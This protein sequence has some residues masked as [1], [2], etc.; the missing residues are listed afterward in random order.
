MLED[1]TCSNSTP[2]PDWQ[3]L[4]SL[5]DESAVKHHHLCP[6]QILGIRIGLAG[7]RALN[8]I[9]ESYQSRFR[10]PQKRLLTIVETD[11]C[12]ADGVAVATDC[13]VGRRT[14]RV[15]D[16]GKVA[17]SLV[18][19]LSGRAIRIAPAPVARKLA[20]K[21]AP[22]ESSPWH[23]YLEAY[24][25]M[26][27]GELLVIQPVKLTRSL[28][29]ILSRPGLRVVCQRCGEEIMNE[30]QVLQ[31]GF[32]MCR[33]CAGEAYYRCLPSDKGD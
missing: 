29:E 3:L 33:G 27:D 14:L 28:A 4:S 17:A 16:F 7:L 1:P 32:T 5:M 21:R 24:Q 12:G 23:S 22:D 26:P 6:R 20:L 25:T 13:F 10:N 9:D 19:T 18:D 11:G 30:R 2:V 31:D 15:L 8:L